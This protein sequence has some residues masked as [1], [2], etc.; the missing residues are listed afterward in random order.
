VANAQFPDKIDELQPV[1]QLYISVDAATK[2]SLKK[3]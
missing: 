2:D 3:N 1:T